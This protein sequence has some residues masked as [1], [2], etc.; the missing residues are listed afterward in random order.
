MINPDKNIQDVFDFNDYASI[1]LDNFA[2]KFSVE[3]GLLRLTTESDEFDPDEY[4]HM[5]TD[6]G[7]RL[8]HKMRDMLIKVGCRH[9]DE[10]EVEVDSI[11]IHEC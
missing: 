4:P 6:Q 2:K 10:S 5:L 1:L 3:N 9:F 11:F 7:D 8:F